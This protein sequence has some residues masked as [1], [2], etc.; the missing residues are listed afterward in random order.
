[1]KIRNFSNMTESELTVIRNYARKIG[2]TEVNIYDNQKDD[3]DETPESIYFLRGRE[4]IA[5]YWF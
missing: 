1:M 4:V 2:A 5:S 3:D